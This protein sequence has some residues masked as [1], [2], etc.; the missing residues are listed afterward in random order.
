MMMNK[1]IAITF[2][3]ILS[4]AVIILTGGFIYLL[5][6][7]I[8]WNSFSFSIDS[9]SDK[10]VD[11]KTYE[12]ADE[13]SIESKAIDIYVEESTDNMI[14][15]QLYSDKD[16]NYDIT[17]EDNKI[18]IKASMESKWSLFDKGSKLVIKL[19]KD[20]ANKFNIVSDINDIKISSFDNLRP[21]IKNGTGDVKI[22][23]VNEAT[24]SNNIGDIKIGTA[25]L[26]NIK[27]VTG[28][29]KVDTINGKLNINNSTGDIKI[30]NANLNENSNISN[31]TGDIKID[32]LKGAYIE[33]TNNVGDI[34]VN[35]NDRNLEL[36]CTVHTNIGDIKIN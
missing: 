13:I 27:N 36:T 29:I 5:N 11:T 23:K 35:N 21:T 19:P 2:I 10:L 22:V 24:I 18:S 25:N 6:G 31:K 34:R 33:A 30:R 17:N 26:L 1:S 7:N 12:V 3:V 14:T 28:D 4:C 8:N 9:H 32:L 16:V 20:Y 15:T